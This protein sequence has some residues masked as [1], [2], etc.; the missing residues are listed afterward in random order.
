MGSQPLETLMKS[1][2]LK[3][4]QNLF[5]PGFFQGAV[6]AIGFTSLVSIAATNFPGYF[7]FSSGTPISSSEINSNFE[8]LTGTILLKAVYSG[9]ITANESNF[10]VPT[11]CPTCHSYSK[12]LLLSSASV[13]AANLL[14][15]TDSDA[16]SASYGTSFSYIS[17]PSDG[18]YEFRLITNATASLAGTTC[19]SINCNA[20]V[21]A[22]SAITLATSLANAQGFSQGV[23]MAWISSY[24]NL[25]DQN[26]DGVFDAQ[27]N[28]YA[29]MPPEIKRYYLKAG[30]ILYFS[31]NASYNQNVSTISANVSNSSMDFTIIKL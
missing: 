4:R 17:I 31:F 29:N 26:S 11:Y 6:V 22:N 25:N 14:T 27:S 20:N 24:D 19:N 10:I 13:G 2:L 5:R 28:L 7:I 21:N 23:S 8:K 30:Q 18:W 9:S 16:D 1:L 15:T 12:K 3:F